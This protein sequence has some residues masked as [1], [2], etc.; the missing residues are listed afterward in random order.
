[1]PT[2]ENVSLAHTDER[3]KRII[4]A[5]ESIAAALRLSPRMH[6]EHAAI[7]AGIHPRTYWRYMAGEDEVS[8]AF[9]AIVLP[10]VHDQADAN[11]T[12]A[13][14]AIGCSENG[15][16]AW[17]GWHRWLME[18]RYRKIYGDLAQEVKVE[19][20]G[21]DG[22]AVQVQAI[23]TR[24]QALAELRELAKGDPE[25]ARLLRESGES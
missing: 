4:A 21:K 3:R 5:A 9:Q 12:E 6:Q 8:E 18:K 23:P 13:E 11:L 15:S 19:L 16:G 14:V 22:G 2:D 20:T 17:A 25:V 7:K 10:A 24:E 1:M